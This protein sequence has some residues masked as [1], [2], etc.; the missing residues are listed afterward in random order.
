MGIRENV[1]LADIV[2]KHGVTLDQI[3]DLRSAM[4]RTWGDIC[5]DLV[6]CFGSEEEMEAAYDD[7]AAMNAENTIDA[8][9]VVSLCP[10]MDLGWVYRLEDGSCR[11][12]CIQMGEDILRAGR[13]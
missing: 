8:D 13:G 7:D 9:R 3:A 6:E 4:S 1:T 5:Y 11:T 12:N 2:V 10:D